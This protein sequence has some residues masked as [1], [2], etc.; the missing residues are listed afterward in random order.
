VAWDTVG[1]IVARVT[2]DHRDERRLEGL[3]AIGVET[4]CA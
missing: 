1:R 4:A 3:V 2:A